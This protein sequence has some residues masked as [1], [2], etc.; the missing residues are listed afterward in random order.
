MRR[1]VTI[2][3]AALGATAAALGVVVAV[4][5]RGNRLEA[6]FSDRAVASA[7]VLAGCAPRDDTARFSGCRPPLILP[8][9]AYP[10][11]RSALCAPGRPLR[12]VRAPPYERPDGAHS[13]RR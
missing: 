8:R 2:G 12:V 5:A 3:V 13:W 10:P 4:R 7:E 9:V 11:E 1:E 6:E